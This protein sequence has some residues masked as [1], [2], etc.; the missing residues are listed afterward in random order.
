MKAKLKTTVYCLSLAK[1]GLD[2]GRKELQSE[3]LEM[4][5]KWAGDIGQ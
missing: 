2:L 5:R 4:I 3:L 1:E